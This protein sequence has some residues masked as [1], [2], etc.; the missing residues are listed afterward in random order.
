M[1]CHAVGADVVHALKPQ[2]PR[3]RAVHAALAPYLVGPG[4][5]GI[6]GSSRYAVKA[7]G[8]VRQAAGA[9][10]G[11]PVLNGGEPAWKK[12]D[13]AAMIHFRLRPRRQLMVSS[14]EP[15]LRQ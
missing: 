9:L 1:A 3:F 11:R 2:L 13:A 4:A 14:M 12:D 8:S 15:L 6:V 7:E 10:S 5:A